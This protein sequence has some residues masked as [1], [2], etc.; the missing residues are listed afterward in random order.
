MAEGSTPNAP[1]LE[2]ATARA[3]AALTS[4]IGAWIMGNSILAAPAAFSSAWTASA[5]ALRGLA[6][7]GLKTRNRGPGRRH[8]SD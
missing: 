8:G 2:T 4:A 1:A 7:T 5:V 3:G 6:V